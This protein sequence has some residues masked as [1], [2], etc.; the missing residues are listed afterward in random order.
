MS[1]SFLSFYGNLH[2]S[3]GSIWPRS[4]KRKES[5]NDY[6][7]VPDYTKRQN[8][9]P[10]KRLDFSGRFHQTVLWKCLELRKRREHEQCCFKLLPGGWV[11]LWIY[12]FQLVHLTSKWY[13]HLGKDL[14][15]N[16]FCCIT[17]TVLPRF[18]V[19]H[20]QFDT[21]LPSVSVYN[22]V[23]SSEN[24]L[25]CP[26]IFAFQVLTAA[27]WSILVKQM[28]V[29]LCALWSTSNLIQLYP[30]DEL[31]NVLVIWS[32]HVISSRYD[33]TRNKHL[34]DGREH[35]D[36]KWSIGTN[37]LQWLN[38]SE[39]WCHKDRRREES[40][41]WF[42]QDSG[43]EHRTWRSK[44]RNVGWQGKWMSAA[45]SLTSTFILRLTLCLQK[46]E[47]KGE[48][49]SQESAGKDTFEF[50][51]GDHCSFSVEPFYP[52]SFFQS[53]RMLRFGDPCIV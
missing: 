10:S 24:W 19:D 6:L 32:L 22:D 50:L 1:H 4:M 3:R 16:N 52:R 26:V 2:L 35:Q 5:A 53:N 45:W 40:G 31:Q 8:L 34:W 15:S 23:K 7:A 38:S 33:L 9:V 39:R 12:A 29:V 41:W 13:I 44:Q 42:C 25:W 36:N 20:T 51:N 37:A 17:S 27:A 21:P 49:D 30:S 14:F 18:H 47:K 48:H 11:K 43:C 28:K 46:H